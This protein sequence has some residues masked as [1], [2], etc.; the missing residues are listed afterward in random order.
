MST[1]G[2]RNPGI[3]DTICSGRV[4]RDTTEGVTDVRKLTA[5]GLAG[6]LA[7]AAVVGSGVAA[8]AP[9]V[10]GQT[11]AKAKDTLSTAGLTPIVVTRV[12]DRLSD[13]D[14]I[15]D[16]IQDSNFVSG[17]GAPA[18]NTVS[19]YLNC[20]GNVASNKAPGYSAQNPMGKT[21]QANQSQ[22]AS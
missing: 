22:S 10:T 1:E 21:V 12:G 5:I 18:T 16:R 3:D 6:G 19:I 11:Y 4:A 8:A 13:D 17:T 15:V 20:D 9:D 7:I 2:S 14:C